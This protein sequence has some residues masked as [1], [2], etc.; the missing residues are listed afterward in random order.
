MAERDPWASDLRE[1]NARDRSGGDFK[2]PRPRCRTQPLTSVHGMFVTRRRPAEARV[3]A[4]R[5]GHCFSILSVPRGFLSCPLSLGRGHSRES[6]RIAR[7]ATAGRCELFGVVSIPLA[8]YS[9]APWPASFFLT[10]IN[11]HFHFQPEHRSWLISISSIPKSS[12]MPSA[13]VSTR[14]ANNPCCAKSK[15]LN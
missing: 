13:R 15:R 1:P 5:G 3:A 4:L 11:E 9:S 12:P 6:P 2:Y 10:L 7:T 8:K 14:K